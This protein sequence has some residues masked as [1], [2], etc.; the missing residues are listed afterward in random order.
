MDLD[1][2]ELRDGAATVRPRRSTI[3]AL[4]VAGHGEGGR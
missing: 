2:A 1:S 3:P 4:P